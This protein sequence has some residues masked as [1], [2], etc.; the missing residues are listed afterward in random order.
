MPPPGTGLR[1]LGGSKRWTVNQMPGPVSDSYDPEFSTGA[2]AHDVR[3]GIQS[4]IDRIGG[5]LGPGLRNIVQVAQEEPGE[6]TGL[7]FDERQLRLI[8]FGLL[9]VLDSI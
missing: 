4:V 9:R 1:G 5:H 3:S 7:T 2:R 8:R 6:P